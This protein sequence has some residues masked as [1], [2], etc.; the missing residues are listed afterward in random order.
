MELLALRRVAK[1]FETAGLGALTSIPIGYADVT[2]T[3]VREAVERI[4]GDRA[5]IGGAASYAHGDLSD[6]VAV[7]VATPVTVCV[8]AMGIASNGGMLSSRRRAGCGFRPAWRRSRL[9][10][11]RLSRA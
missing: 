4:G 8:V 9:I 11:R 3:V 6:R 7:I 10:E 2:G 5:Q 1:S